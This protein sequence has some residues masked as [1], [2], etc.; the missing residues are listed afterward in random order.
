MFHG[1]IPDLVL[2]G[3]VAGWLITQVLTTGGAW[4][5]LRDG[6]K[7]RDEVVEHFDKELTVL[8]NELGEPEALGARFDASRAEIQA[9]VE[10][11]RTT[12]EA[13][14]DDLRVDERIAEVRDDVR[15][16]YED[17]AGFA[18]SLGEDI[19]GTKSDLKDLPLRLQLRLGGEKGTEVAALQRYM[20]TQE[21]EEIEPG[22]SMMEAVASEDPDLIVGTALAKVAA[23]S[24][25]EKWV[26][27][28]PITAAA[29]EIGKPLI[30]Q[31]L[32]EFMGVE[33]RNRGLRNSA[34]KTG[35]YASP[36]G[37]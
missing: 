1:E 30:M 24:P 37:K 21:G 28:H 9:H 13:R 10:D 17:F 35:N 19:A 20:E 7:K 32:A 16:F 31:K 8:K 27:E 29:L 6:A 15:T 2:W 14:L 23:Y 22:L 5:L 33:G 26:G 11:V 34:G 25:S 12:L 4:Y 36:Y 3:L 18:K